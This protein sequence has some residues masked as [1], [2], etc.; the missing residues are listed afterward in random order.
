MRK[1]RVAR[2]TPPRRTA[3]QSSTL[4]RLEVG[5]ALSLLHRLLSAHPDLRPEAE[6]MARA[7]LGEIDFEAVADEVEDGLRALDLDDLDGRAG[8]HR[9][10]YTDPTEAAWDLLQEVVDPF[11]ANMKRQMELGLA[12]EAL[13][14]CKGILLGLYRI[15]GLKGD[16]FL[17]WAPDFPEEAAAQ[18]VSGL[19]GRD[20]PKA[21]RAAARPR[22]DGAF[23]DKNLPEWR[24]LIA[25]CHGRA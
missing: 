17:G 4:E 10:G 1:G 2:V 9:G 20:A 8:R 25:R 22:L 18:A 11:L 19:A 13:E 21:T 14:T 24:E 5:E 6:Q 12:A 23:L 7:L 3:K 16:E 15:R